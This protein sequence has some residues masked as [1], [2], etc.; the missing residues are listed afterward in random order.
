MAA[1][2][3]QCGALFYLKRFAIG[4][5]LARHDAPPGAPGLL[6]IVRHLQFQ[7]QNL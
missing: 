2:V 7:V 3:L 5:E 6:T 4:S 1:L